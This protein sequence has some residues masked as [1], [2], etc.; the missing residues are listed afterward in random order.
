[1]N[2]FKAIKVNQDGE[3]LTVQLYRPQDRN[4]INMQ[5]VNDLLDVVKFAYDSSDISIFVIRGMRDI[6][7]S[8]VDLHNFTPDKEPD[9]YGFQKWE[10]MCSLLHRMEKLTI[11]AV[12]GECNGGGFDLMLLCDIRIAEKKAIF[13]F[14]EMKMSFVPGM[15]TYR[16]SKYI[17]LGRAKNLIMTGKSLSASKAL[18]WGLLDTVPDIHEIDDAIKQ[19]ID[20]CTPFHSVPNLLVRRLLDECYAETYEDFLG[21]YLA[22]QHRAIHSESFIKLISNTARKSVKK[23]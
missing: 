9:I 13:R 22:A 11:A 12:E 3:V 17:G 2:K 6:F 21:H 18:E 20:E 5:M 7:C 1:M 19:S 23:K 14:D 16:L 15:T 10:K 8:G 4:S